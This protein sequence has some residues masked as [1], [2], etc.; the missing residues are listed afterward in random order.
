MPYFI[1]MN[2]VYIDAVELKKTILQCVTDI[3]HY[4]TN[5]IDEYINK[6]TTEFSKN[7]SF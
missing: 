6:K 7:M 4:F 5:Q 2:L 1:R 3:I